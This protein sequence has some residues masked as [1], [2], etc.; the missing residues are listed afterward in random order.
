MDITAVDS[1]KS[2]LKATLLSSQDQLPGFP[3]ELDALTDLAQLETWARNL[4]VTQLGSERSG[5]D[6]VIYWLLFQAF[7][8]ERNGETAFLQAFTEWMGEQIQ[9]SPN[10]IRMKREVACVRRNLDRPESAMKDRD[11][12]WLVDYKQNAYE[13]ASRLATELTEQSPDFWVKAARWMAEYD[14]S[15]QTLAIT[16]YR[17]RRSREA[18]AQKGLH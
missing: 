6:W 14:S 15:H 4:N 1:F 8:C 5:A 10:D 9:E 16:L 13:A 7:W 17:M 2:L 18:A 3:E 11:G 12:M